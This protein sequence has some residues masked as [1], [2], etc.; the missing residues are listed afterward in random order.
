MGDSL[1]TRFDPK[2]KTWTEPRT[3]AVGMDDQDGFQA[4]GVDED[5]N[6]TVLYRRR[7]GEVYRGY[8]VRY[9]QRR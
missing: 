2:Q 5:G 7:E 1:A 6:V 4:I 8:A 3:L 9:Q